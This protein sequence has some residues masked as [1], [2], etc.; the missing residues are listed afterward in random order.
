MT[1]LHDYTAARKSLRTD[2]VP[3]LVAAIMPVLD[4]VG[5]EY[6]PLPGEELGLIVSLPDGSLPERYRLRI[7][8]T[9][10]NTASWK[11]PDGTQTEGPGF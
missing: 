6:E 10:I 9:A 3:K 1:Y 5:A 2:V 8:F 4:R 11:A 7:D